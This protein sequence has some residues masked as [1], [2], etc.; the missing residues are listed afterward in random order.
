MNRIFTQLEQHQEA[1]VKRQR[2]W[3]WGAMKYRKLFNGKYGMIRP[4]LK[5]HRN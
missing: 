2:A 3:D 1:E 4:K 5:P